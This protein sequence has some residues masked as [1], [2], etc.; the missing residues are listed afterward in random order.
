MTSPGRQKNPSITTACRIAAST[1]P[2]SRRSFV[3][4][5]V[6]AIPFQSAN[7]ASVSKQKHS[8]TVFVKQPE[9]FASPAWKRLSQDSIKRKE[10]AFGRA[11]SLGKARS[12]L[13]DKSGKRQKCSDSHSNTI[14]HC[15]AKSM[16]V[17]HKFR[18][19]R[20][21][22]PTVTASRGG[23]GTDPDDARAAGVLGRI[24]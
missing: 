3:S 9:Q 10:I 21:T 17:W 7:Y 8:L 19:S 1:S 2:D 23:G 18:S 13:M 12:L 16:P 6:R 5:A 11:K 4:R 24:D 20:S 14:D 22:R 15:D